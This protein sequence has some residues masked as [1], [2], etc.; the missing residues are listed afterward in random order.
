MDSRILLP[1]LLALFAGLA[2]LIGFA[3]TFVAKRTNRK[4]LSYSLGL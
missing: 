2:T 3:I 1:F 4:L